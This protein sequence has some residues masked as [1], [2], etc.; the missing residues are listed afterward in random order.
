MYIYI[1]MYVCMY[2]Y[3]YIHAGAHARPNV[4]YP[5]SRTRSLRRPSAWWTSDSPRTAWSFGWD[6]DGTRSTAMVHPTDPVGERSPQVF[7]WMK[8]THIPVFWVGWTNPPTRFV[9]SSPPSIVISTTIDFSLLYQAFS[10]H[11]DVM[12]QCCVWHAKNDTWA[13]LGSPVW[14]T[15]ESQWHVSI[16]PFCR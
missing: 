4:V 1:Y 9:G 2:V 6:Q 7:R 14:S 3:I 12:F 13:Y 16:P 15:V 5:G 8:P 10:E 11:S